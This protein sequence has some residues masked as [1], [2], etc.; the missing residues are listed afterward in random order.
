MLINILNIVLY[1]IF[2][3]YV[4]IL[5]LNLIIILNTIF[6]YTLNIKKKKIVKF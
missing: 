1:I 5:I 2:L 6:F 3:K 4:F